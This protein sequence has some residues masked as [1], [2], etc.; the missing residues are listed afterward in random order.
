MPIPGLN[1]AVVQAINV[2]RSISDDV[3]AVYIT[4]DQSRRSG[5]CASGSSDRCRACRWSSSSRRTGRWPARSSPISTS[6]TAPGRPTSPSRSRSSSSPST[7]RASW[8]ERH[9]LQPVREAAADGPARAAAHGRRQRPVPA[10]GPGTLRSRARRHRSG[11]EGRAGD[12]RQGRTPA[13]PLTGRPSRLVEAWMCAWRPCTAR[14][15]DPTTG[16]AGGG[17][18]TAVHVRHAHTRV[19]ARAHRPQRWPERRADRPPRRRVGAPL[20]GRA[21]RRPRRR[22]RLDAA[23]RRGHRRAF[24]GGPARARQRGDRRR[25]IE[26]P[27]GAG[28]AAGP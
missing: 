22:D 4:D 16:A 12:P 13:G 26:G 18:V 19:P 11:E 24:R 8:W 7:S 20:E 1:R 14:S 25:R 17:I 3:R 10:R 5:S 9:P 21:D 27:A 23:A 15:S 6:S 28:P 2:A